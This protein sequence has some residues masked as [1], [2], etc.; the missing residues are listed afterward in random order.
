MDY[1]DSSTYVTFYT[2]GISIYLPFQLP[3]EHTDRAAFHC[4]GVM[5]HIAISFLH[6]RPSYLYRIEVKPV[7]VKYITNIKMQ[8]C[9]SFEMG[10]ARYLSETMSVLSGD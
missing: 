10:G 9:T 1:K 5:I 3:G 6:G 2:P 8:L 4:W 7:R